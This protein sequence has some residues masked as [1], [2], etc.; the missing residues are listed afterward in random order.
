M[1][2][3]VPVL[4]LLFIS[5]LSCSPKPNNASKWI[6]KQ[7][8]EVFD[9]KFETTKGDFIVTFKRDWSP[10][11]VDRV[12]QLIQSEFYTDIAV[13]RVA[14]NYV[15]QFGISNDTVKNAYW[16]KHKI[17]DEAVKKQNIAR[18]VAFARG[19]PETRSTQLFINLKN[20]SPRLDTLK[21]RNVTGFPV[22]GEVISGWDVVEQF[23]DKYGNEPAMRQDSISISGNAYLKTVFPNLDYIHKVSVIK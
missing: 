1:K 6:N 4:V 19:G 12:Y 13:Y 2:L 22:V 9:A 3:S 17:P 8:P 14:P 5:M 7:A 23:Y 18:T 15:A 21:Y 20:N 11:A 16:T 10:L